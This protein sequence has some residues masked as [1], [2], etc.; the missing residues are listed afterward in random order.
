MT[1]GVDTPNIQSLPDRA[2][3]SSR[4]TA[5]RQPRQPGRATET[6]GTRQPEQRRQHGSRSGRT[7]L[8][9]CRLA[10]AGVARV[11][12]AL[13]EPRQPDPFGALAR[14]ANQGSDLIGKR[15]RAR[16]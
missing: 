11:Y 16:Y 8:H 9:A 15:I 13:G 1:S 12:R 3:L 2:L 5:A 6:A 14:G 10:P 7:S 4:W